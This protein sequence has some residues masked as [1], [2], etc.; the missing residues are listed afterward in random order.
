MPA[1]LTPAFILDK[2]GY[3]RIAYGAV[4][5]EIK[6]NFMPLDPEAEDRLLAIVQSLC[7]ECFEAHQLLGKWRLQDQGLWVEPSCQPSL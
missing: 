2:G 7:E 3:E 4:L 1:H 6:K 5:M